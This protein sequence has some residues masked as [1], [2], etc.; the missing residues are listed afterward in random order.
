[1]SLTPVLCGLLRHSTVLEV[2]IIWLTYHI[3]VEKQSY[4]IVRTVLSNGNSGLSPHRFFIKE[5]KNL[6]LW[7][8][9][10]DWDSTWNYMQISVADL[11][12][13][14]IKIE[15]IRIVVSN[16]S[17]L[18]GRNPWRLICSPDCHLIR[19]LRFVCGFYRLL[20]VPFNKGTAWISLKQNSTTTCWK[21]NHWKIRIALE[22]GL[23]KAANF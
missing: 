21:P 12:Y 11:V 14:L 23:Q 2:T 19:P 10:S 6:K 13:W 7:W 16:W 3:V 22:C 1:M 5:K 8:T 18:F 17:C 20:D 4:L 9:P 15:H